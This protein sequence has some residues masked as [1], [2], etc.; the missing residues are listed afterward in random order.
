VKENSRE[1]EKKKW[2]REGEEEG[3]R[4]VREEGVKSR[5]ETAAEWRRPQIYPK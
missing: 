5:E 1:E 2:Y 3:E 4:K